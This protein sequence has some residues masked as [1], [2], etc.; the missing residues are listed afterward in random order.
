M[1]LFAE[2]RHEVGSSSYRV[3]EVY[4]ECGLPDVDALQLT[5]DA[6][7]GSEAGVVVGLEH[8]EF[9]DS[10]ALAALVR[11]HTRG[12]ADGRQFVMAAP[13]AQVRRVLRVSRLDTRGLVFDSV[14]D[15]L[16][17]PARLV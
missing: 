14:E 1:S 9:I 13:S 15:A 7:D 4:G 3:I 11:V 10:M 12:R 5:L 6:T 2:N 8:C 17:E 16:A